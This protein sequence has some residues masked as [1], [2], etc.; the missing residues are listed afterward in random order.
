MCDNIPS[1][2]GIMLESMFSENKLTSWNI[3]GKGNMTYVTLRFDMRSP[4]LDTNTTTKYKK[5]TPSA[6]LCDKRRAATMRSKKGSNAI[7][8]QQDSLINGEENMKNKTENTAHNSIADDSI[9]CGQD[10]GVDIVPD[11]DDDQKSSAT[12]VDSSPES[13][14][15]DK[16]TGSNVSVASSGVWGLCNECGGDLIDDEHKY[17]YRCTT[18]EEYDTCVSCFNSGLHSQHYEQVTKFQEPERPDEGYCNAC[19]QQFDPHRS[20]FDIFQCEECEDYALCFR[21]KYGGKHK[22]HRKHFIQ[23]SLCGYLDSLK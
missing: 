20:Y 6:L 17:W 8:E 7:L 4:S 3:N 16:V 9:E 22:H 23:R 11:D 14:D 5:A 21:C 19:G 2:L 13:V 18:C 15:G 1:A 12:S 10:Q